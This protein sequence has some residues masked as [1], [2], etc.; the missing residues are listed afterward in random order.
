MSTSG[1]YMSLKQTLSTLNI[2]EGYLEWLLL[3]EQLFSTPVIVCTVITWCI[4][5][6]QKQ[7]VRPVNIYVAL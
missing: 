1:S 7:S 6:Q 4:N 2:S 5:E 3:Y